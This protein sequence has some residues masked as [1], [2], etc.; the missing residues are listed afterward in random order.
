MAEPPGKSADPAP[1]SGK[2]TRDARGNAVWSWVTETGKVAIDSTSRLLKRLDASDLKLEGS[3][4]DQKADAPVNTSPDPKTGSRPLAGQ[5]GYDPYSSKLAPR[6]TQVPMPRP[7]PRPMPTAPKPGLKPATARKS[8][9]G[10]LF[11]GK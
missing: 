6:K 5:Q 9:F 11:G 10:R 3:E 8:F 7:I 4:D 2:V 1:A